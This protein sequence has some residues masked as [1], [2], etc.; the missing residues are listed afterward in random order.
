MK[1]EIDAIL[2]RNQGAA[3]KGDSIM[4]L[5]WEQSTELSVAILDMISLDACGN[6]YTGISLHHWV[7]VLALCGFSMILG[8]SDLF[9]LNHMTPAF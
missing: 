6:T 5:L 3:D 9:N 1:V 2:G 4:F 7:N 8:V